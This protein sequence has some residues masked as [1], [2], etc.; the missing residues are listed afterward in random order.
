ML[1]SN[2]SLFPQISGIFVH[3]TAAMNSCGCYLERHFQPAA[4]HCLVVGPHWHSKKPLCSTRPHGV[5]FMDPECCL[6][7]CR[8]GAKIKQSRKKIR[9]MAG[10]PSI[11]SSIKPQ[12]PSEAGTSQ[13]PMISLPCQS[14][15]HQPHNHHCLPKQL[16]LKGLLYED[17]IRPSNDRV[18]S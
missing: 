18:H 14:L 9:R 15:L 5:F 10:A 1:G 11:C 12:G 13:L 16:L 8:E 4:L 3:S 17:V 6:L 2:I 7:M